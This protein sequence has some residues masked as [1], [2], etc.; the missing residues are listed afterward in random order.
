MFKVGFIYP[1]YEN[2]GIEY[3]SAN[4]KKNGFN[5]RL[6]LDPVLFSE[7]G[8][9]DNKLLA[10]LFSFRKYLLKEIINYQPDLLCFSVITD[11][12][13]WA[14]EWAKEI[15]KY[16]SVPIIFGGIHPT[17][18]PDIVIKHQCI[19]FVCVGEGEETIVELAQ[20]IKNGVK[21]YSIKNLLFKDNGD[22]IS[23][24]V[25]PLIEDL[26]KLP[27]PDKDFYYQKYK[28]MFK[29]YT[30]ITSRG[31]PH[32]CTYC[33]NSILKNIYQN[34]GKYLR[35]RSVDNVLEELKIAKEKYRPR[36]IHFSDEVFT[37]D[38]D[39]LKKFIPLY[40]QKI[41]LPFFCYTSPA[42][43]AGEIVRLLKEGGCYKV[44]MGV[45]TLNEQKRTNL[46]NRHYTNEQI[47]QAIE[48]FKKNKIYLTCDNI[49]GLPNQDERGL[50]KMAEFYSVNKPNHIEV[51]W[52]RYYPRTP[53]VDIA[54]SIGVIDDNKKEAIEKGLN[55]IGIARG[56][57]TFKPEFVRFQLL[58]NLFHFLPKILCNF[59]LRKKI[60]N[61]LPA[62]KPISITVFFRL[63][64]RA[65]FDLYTSTTVKRYIYFIRKIFIPFF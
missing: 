41:G 43:I 48:I 44:Q 7:S 18:T 42:F 39:W 21:N 16:I 56:G 27:L 29:G 49:F 15:K 20:A 12:Y 33:A 26:D 10:T 46:L 64:N 28:F 6:F 17:S 62:L 13:L 51:F 37:Y 30:I 45:Q 4:L 2:L 11:N 25:R 1:A 14:C 23:N 19:D 32:S 36:F 3:L 9:I 61:L 50:I 8:I 60:Y 5:S 38:R 35:R 63:F 53:I 59:M 65:R 31:C 24:E 54:Q 40:T 58:L 55:A 34:K 22:I 52:L 47:A 57:D